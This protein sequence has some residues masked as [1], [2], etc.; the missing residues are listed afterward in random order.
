MID[1]HRLFGLALCDLF[2]GS[3]W[4]VELE[5][6]L[7]Q[8]RQLLDVVILRRGPGEF[9]GQLPDGLE[10]LADHNLLSYK[11]LR[12]PL[13]DWALKELT[14]HYV[15]YHKQVSRK[16]LLPE[17][18]F[19]LF[20]VCARFP[21]KLAAQLRLEPS[22]P[23]VY[24][25][26]RGTDRIVVIVLS[27]IA[28]EE[29]NSL[30]HL[31]SAVPEVVRFGAG[32]YRRH[33]ADMSGIVNKLFKRYELEGIAM[34]YTIEDFRREYLAELPPEERLKGLSPDERLEGLSPDERLEGL[35][36]DERLVGL[37]LEERL[38][39]LSPDEIKAYLKKLE[40]A[41]KPKRRSAAKQRNPNRRKGQK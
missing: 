21:Q 34:P 18:S 35:S 27:E 37:S 9:V 24:L 33:M 22:H 5:K 17:E 3:P 29:H 16:E 4:I 1:W 23:G 8:K 2:A 25:L 36:P 15:N 31:F 26:Q 13:D 19:Q 12:E 10:H 28:R 11:S 7:S 40:Q 32:H 38:R 30:W 20:G 39:G 14:G 41:K 6:D